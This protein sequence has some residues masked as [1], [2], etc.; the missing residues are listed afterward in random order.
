MNNNFE[1]VSTIIANRRTV[2]P[3]AMNGKKIEDATIM[4][5]LSLAD[6]APTHGKTEPWRFNVFTG[7]ALQQFC[8]EHAEMYWQN[9][10]K[11]TRLQ[12]TY[13]NLKG[14]GDQCSHLII[15]T[16]RRTPETK[17]PFLEEYAATAAAIQNI[18]L[19]AEAMDIAAIWNT[20]GMALKPAMKQYLQ[21]QP[22][23]EVVAF[24]YL[25]YTDQPKKE[26]ARNKPLSEK[27]NWR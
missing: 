3:A 26:G 11:N 13:N 2:K 27:V 24:L 25:G 8:A 20:G 15:A 21:L 7:A 17:I 16:M 22:E 9:T 23:D 14:M 6:W 4:Q 18:L 5:L 10:D 19:G 12:Q 1:L